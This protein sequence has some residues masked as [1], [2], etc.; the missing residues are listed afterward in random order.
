M[1]CH[2]EAEAVKKPSNPSCKRQNN[3]VSLTEKAPQTADI[4]TKRWKHL[5]HQKLATDIAQPVELLLAVLAPP[6]ALIQWVPAIYAV[7][8]VKHTSSKQ[9]I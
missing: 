3:S 7:S 5:L 1:L 9:W 4:T 8:G 6:V 2:A